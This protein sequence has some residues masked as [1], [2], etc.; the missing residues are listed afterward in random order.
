MGSLLTLVGIIMLVPLLVSINN[1]YS[2]AKQK[3]KQ[4]SES[5]IEANQL[6][7]F[8]RE[9]HFDDPSSSLILISQLE[10]D[11]QELLKTFSRKLEVFPDNCEAAL[12]KLRV[13]AAPQLGK[14]NRVSEALRHLCKIP[15]DSEVFVEAQV[16]LDHWYKSPNWG[17]QTKFY[18]Q[19]VTKN[20]ASRCPAASF[21]ESGEQKK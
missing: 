20:N 10:R 15:S 8:C 18:L 19:E 6:K 1:Y 2:L 4:A 9:I 3:E 21:I 11:K 7:Q 17:K 13:L 14:E 16:W 5:L 12:N